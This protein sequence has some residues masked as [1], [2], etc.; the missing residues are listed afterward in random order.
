MAVLARRTGFVMEDVVFDSD[1]FQFWASEQYTRDIPLRDPRS[2]AV[3]RNAGLFSEALIE[4]YR[5]QAAELNR[6]RDGDSACFY[7]RR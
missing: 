1:E 4:T 6:V 2:F 5:R 3:D 7:L